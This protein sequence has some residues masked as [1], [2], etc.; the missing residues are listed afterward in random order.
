MQFSYRALDSSGF[1]Q[2]G[3]L[4]VDSE[5]AAL[6]ILQEREYAPLEL[7]ALHT[8]TGQPTFSASQTIKHGDIVALI[9][10]LATLLA[11]GVGLSES[12]T[13]LLEAT[14]H[15]G[16]KE[17]LAQ[18]NQSVRSGEGFSAALHKSPLKLPQYVYALSRAGEETGDLG[19]AL[20]RCAEQLEFEDRMRNEAKEALTYPLILIGTGV[21]AIAFIFSFVVPRF[22]GILQGRNVDLP[23]LSQWVL[24]TG[25]YV[26]NH[27]LGLGVALAALVALIIMAARNRQTGALLMSALSRLPLLS[28]WV[29]G[30]ETARWTS[31]L[32]VLLQSRVSILMCIELAAASVRLPE[33]VTRLKNVE[34]DVRRGKQFSTA[35]EERRLLEGSSL[36]MLKVGEKSGQLG[37]MLEHVA[38][39]TAEKHR[40]MQRRL[41]SLIEPISI[42]IIGL[43]LG[44]IMAGVVLAM[45]SLTEIK[46]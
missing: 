25:M 15:R 32:A 6:A 10:E 17:A 39:H 20:A 27:W 28:D 21:A 5:A 33:N 18:L 31:M 19:S 3:T 14:S 30:A 44:V 26:H 7:K 38:A 4:E 35:I 1:I 29:A 23:L 9:R 45:T 43:S 34:D 11:S 12:F 16:M 24:G 22:A 36:T 13:T 37:N 41:V 46:L 2:K 42:L 40:S 8:A